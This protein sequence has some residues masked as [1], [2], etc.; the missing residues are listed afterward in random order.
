LRIHAREMVERVLAARGKRGWLDPDTYFGSRSVD[1]ALRAAGSTI[2][3]ALAIWRKRWRR[4]FTLV[5]PPGHHA[6][7]D[8]PMGFCLFNNVACAVAAVLSES[9]GARLAVVDFDLHHGNGTQW[10]FY[11]NPNVLF[12]SSH[13]YPF[14]PGTGAL[15][16]VG[17]GKGRG[18]TVNFPV[19]TAEGHALFA[20][21]YG[22]IA[23][24]LIEAFRPEMIL[25]S[26][27][28]DGHRRDPMRGFR[29]ET[30]TY[31]FL[32]ELLIA[33]AERSAE[34]RILFALEGGYDPGALADSAQEVLREM[35][36]APRAAVSIPVPASCEP[37]GA[38]EPWRA[39][40]AKYHPVLRCLR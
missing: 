25:V 37:E 38:L 19:P 2:E 1:V 26:A 32:A 11:D 9:P 8:E 22:R 33:A 6:T 40:H 34:G 29:M 35:V 15:E 20:G 5:R 13:R 10:A 16:E 3:L 21:L 28:F 24:P 27:G 7:R 23:A 4:G 30:E 14:Y 39:F 31:R 36:E 18:T 12:L 17:S